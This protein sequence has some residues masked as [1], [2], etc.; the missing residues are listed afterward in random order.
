M[1]HAHLSPGSIGYYSFIVGECLWQSRSQS[2]WGYTF[3]MIKSPGEF[4][5]CGYTSR[6]L[7]SKLREE[8]SLHDLEGYVW[9]YSRRV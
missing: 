6:N 4:P 1:T 9:L 3:G 2:S 7:S 5:Y 8:F